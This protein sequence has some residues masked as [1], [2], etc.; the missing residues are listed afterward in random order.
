MA[1]N[2]SNNSTTLDDNVFDAAQPVVFRGLVAEWPAVH[3][4]LQSDKTLKEYLLQFDVQ[5]PMT[6]YTG[7]PEID[8]RYFYNDALDGFNFSRQRMQLVQVLEK[9]IATADLSEKESYYVGSTM[10]EHWLPG[11]AGENSID[12]QG[13]ENLSSIWLGNQSLI[14]PHFDFPNNI[15]CV[16]AGRRRFRL[17]PPEQSVNLYIGPLDNTPSGQPISLVDL[18]DPDYEKYPKYAE[19]EQAALIFDLQAGDAILIPSMWWHSVEA[20]S[21]FNVLVNYWWRSTPAYLGSPLAALQHAILSFHDLP[22]EQLEAWQSLFAR[23]VFASETGATSHIPDHALGLL[24]DIDESMAKQL[25]Q[26][27]SKSL[28]G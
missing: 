16:V 14:A 18:R 25:R 9:I 26:Q 11:F 1:H 5:R 6:V 22:K 21:D 8:G 19:A 7:A 12:L 27:L 23:Y 28:K 4:G 24:G 3:A 17:F 20:S 2:P 13:R 15:A 10:L